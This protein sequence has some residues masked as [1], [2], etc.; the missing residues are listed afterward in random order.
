MI[1]FS[2]QPLGQ[3]PHIAVLGSSKVG[4]FIVLTPVLRGLKEKYRFCTIDYFGSSTTKSLEQ[5]HRDIDWRCSLECSSESLLKTVESR[6][7]FYGK[8]DLVINC[9]CLDTKRIIILNNLDATFVAGDIRKIPLNY[10]NESTLD[11]RV[12]A[13]SLSPNWSK[14]SIVS[15]YPDILNSNYISEIFCQILYLRTNFNKTE[16]S[17]RQPNFEVP[18]ILIHVTASRQAKQWPV[19]YWQDVLAWCIDRQISIGIVGSH[20]D[21]QLQYYNST[22]IESTLLELDEL[23]DLRGKTSLPELAGA[24]S[25]VKAFLCLDTGPLHIAGAVG[26]NTIAIIGN[27]ED[28]IGA[29]PY[30]LWMPTQTPITRI[31]SSYTCKFCEESSFKNSTCLLEDHMCMLSLHPYQ[32]IKELDKLLRNSI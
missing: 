12:L 20:P 11:T 26:C 30:H 19:K 15:E 3:S 6:K 25:T 18:D 10:E 9:D 29:S 23:I 17:I 13:L 5:V 21:N 27:D 24:L 7:Y 28:G 14:I 8:Y 1:P 31:P 4:G 22:D 32:V 2:N 16:I